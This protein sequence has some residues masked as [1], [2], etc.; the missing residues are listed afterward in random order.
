MNVPQDRSAPSPVCHVLRAEFDVRL[1][2]VAALRVKRN[3]GT[4]GLSG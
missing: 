1:C 4:R 2:C 3:R